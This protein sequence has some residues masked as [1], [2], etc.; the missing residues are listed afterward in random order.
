MF[1]LVDVEVDML[2]ALV[3]VNVGLLSRSALLCYSVEA[4]VVLI[5]GAQGSAGADCTVQRRNITRMS[6]CQEGGKMR[7][8]RRHEFQRH[9]KAKNM[10]TSSKPQFATESVLLIIINRSP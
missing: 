10:M 9:H 1:V 4:E 5:S 6:Q 8:V 3:V 2:D 7:I